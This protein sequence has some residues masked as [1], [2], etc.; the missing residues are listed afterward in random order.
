MARS[1]FKYKK[2]WHTSTKEVFEEIILKLKKDKASDFM[3]A[4][5]EYTAIADSQL[6]KY[7]QK[8]YPERLNEL[9]ELLDIEIFEVPPIGGYTREELN[10]R[11][12]KKRKRV[13]EEAKQQ[14]QSDSETNKG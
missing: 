9:H 14:Q 6:S 11:K 8:N 2:K 5:R 13:R 3:K 12:R 4:F 1:G 10:E 7:I